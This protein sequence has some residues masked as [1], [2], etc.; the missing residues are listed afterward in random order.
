[1]KSAVTAHRSCGVLI[2][3]GEINVALRAACRR[4]SH[5]KNI[6]L[7][8]R[9]PTIASGAGDKPTSANGAAAVADHHP[10]VGKE[11]IPVITKPIA[12]AASTRPTT[13]KLA[14]GLRATG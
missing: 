7:R 4:R 10:Q 6:Q 11:L 2:T 8:A 1:M 14:P 13:S 9:P 3:T 12:S 5:T